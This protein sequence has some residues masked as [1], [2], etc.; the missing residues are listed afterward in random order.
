L[1]THTQLYTTPVWE[2]I[3]ALH[4]AS[5]G[6]LKWNFANPKKVPESLELQDSDTLFGIAKFHL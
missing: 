1:I 5:K 4:M 3:V 2:N 6:T